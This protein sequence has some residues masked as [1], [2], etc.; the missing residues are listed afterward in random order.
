MGVRFSRNS[1]APGD[2]WTA[3]NLSDASWALPYTSNA[4]GSHFKA[5]LGLNDPAI[6]R[7]FLN[8]LGAAACDSCTGGFGAGSKDGGHIDIWLGSGSDP[9]VLHDILHEMGHVVD[10]HVGPNFAYGTAWLDAGKW[11]KPWNLLW[12]SGD[13]KSATSSYALADPGEDFAETFA[14]YVG[15]KQIS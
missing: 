2:A 8:K 15:N 6:N 14:W 9:Q 5:A 1:Q 12:G 13:A 10:Y 3:N 4:F 11:T 7:L